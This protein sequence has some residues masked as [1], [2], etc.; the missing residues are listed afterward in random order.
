[1]LRFIA[2]LHIAEGAQSNQL[3]LNHVKWLRQS[4][5]ALDFMKSNNYSCRLIRNAR[6]IHVV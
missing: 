3:T 1:M 5:P 6:Y 4:E 2:R